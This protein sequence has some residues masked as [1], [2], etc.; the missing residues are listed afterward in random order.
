MTGIFAHFS[1]NRGCGTH[2][3][4]RSWPA[5]IHVFVLLISGFSLVVNPSMSVKAHPENSR[6][7]DLSSI[8]PPSIYVYFSFL[9]PAGIFQLHAVFIFSFH[10][11]IHFYL[12]TLKGMHT[13]AHTHHLHFYT[14]LHR[15]HFV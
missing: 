15:Q 2:L 3:H 1:L 9:T 10:F 12:T 7:S 13:H 8:S 4:T 11:H 5:I 6:R 14:H